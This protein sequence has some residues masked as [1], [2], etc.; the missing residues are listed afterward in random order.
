MFISSH[1]FILCMFLCYRMK[2]TV[3]IL[4]ALMACFIAMTHASG[5][6]AR[7]EQPFSFKTLL[8]DTTDHFSIQQVQPFTANNKE[9]IFTDYV[10]QAYF[11]V[12][13]ETTS[14][15][16]HSYKNTT[17]GDNEITDYK[18]FQVHFDEQYNGT[19]GSITIRNDAEA[20]VELLAFNFSMVNGVALSTGPAKLPSGEQAIY[21]LAAPAPDRFTLTFI[22]A[23][24]T[25]KLYVA[26]KI[27]L[28]VE[29]TFFQKYGSFIM[30]GGLMIFQLYVQSKTKD[31]QQQDPNNAPNDVAALQEEVKKL[32]QQAGVTEPAPA[33]AAA[34]PAAAAKGGKSKAKK[35]D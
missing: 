4:F 35:E 14:L 9:E 5:G 32:R 1:S 25:Q 8:I 26:K 24:G 21:Q 34:A 17:S 31:A 18:Y 28:V 3:F 19:V 16:G 23:N 22:L 33:V 13:N 7:T 29:Q 2:A 6:G 12:Q 10:I 15:L 30:M 11:A 20:Y 27:P